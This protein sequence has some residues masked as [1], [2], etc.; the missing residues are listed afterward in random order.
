MSKPFE[1]YILPLTIV[2]ISALIG[3]L[4]DRLVFSRWRKNIRKTRH[5]VF[6]V[7]GHSMRG[8]LIILMGL[9]GLYIALSYFGIEQEVLS[10]LR[11]LLIVLIIL[12]FTV[13]LA[14]I[15][16]GFIENLGRHRK[17]PSLTLF[18]NLTKI[19]VYVIGF[20][21]ILQTL[22]ISITPLLT[23]LGVGGLAVAL[24]LQDTLSNLFAGIFIIGTRLV[25]PD[26]Y[27]MLS[28]GVEGYVKDVNW[29]NT[30]I[31]TMTNN[32]NVIPN[33]ELSKV[34]I[35]NY[36]R[37]DKKMSLIVPVLIG[38]NNDL[39]KVEEVLIQIARE[40]LN[41]IEG[42]VKD[43]EPLVRFS[44]FGESNI[45]LNL[46]VKVRNYEAQFPIRHELIKRIHQR[47]KEENIEVPYPVR[48]VYL[49]SPG[50]QEI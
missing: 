25:R 50:E 27:I 19:V 33:S 21:I 15:A 35:T 12:T 36:S 29:R 5:P 1:T 23:A 45:S 24:A 11:K 42:G 18:I 48:T 28:G 17:M 47:F 26:D 8:I 44:I 9:V 31:R 40:V 43:S 46:I 38:Y 13:L 30:I 10:S 4:L 39:N 34:I 22:G 32:E 2:V 16:V 14:R 37:P 7:I 3:L 41:E 20:L 49:K 6:K